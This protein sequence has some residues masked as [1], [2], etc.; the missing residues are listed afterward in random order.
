MSFYGV[1]WRDRVDALRLL[2]REIDPVVL[3]PPKDASV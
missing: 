2:L 3:P 1:F